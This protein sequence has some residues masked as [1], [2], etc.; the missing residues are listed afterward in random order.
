MIDIHRTV[1]TVLENVVTEQ[2]YKTV[3]PVCMQQKAFLAAK[4]CVDRE[5]SFDTKHCACRHSPSNSVSRKVVITD[6]V[7]LLSNTMCICF[8]SKF[9][10]PYIYCIRYQPFFGGK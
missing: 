4:L 1:S 8:L 10:M 6:G 2:S 9:S 3:N 5:V 7:R